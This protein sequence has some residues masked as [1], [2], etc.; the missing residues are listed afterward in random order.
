[1]SAS[2]NGIGKDDNSGLKNDSINNND[3]NDNYDNNGNNNGSSNNND[4]NNSDSNNQHNA[5]TVTII[6]KWRD[7]SFSFSLKLSSQISE[8]KLL[9]E[10]LTNVSCSSQKLIGL[11]KKVGLKINDNATIDSIQPSIKNGTIKITLIGKLF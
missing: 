3:S 8:L 2:S 6:V 10:G 11:S 5:E 1:M 4:K 9:I 7:Q